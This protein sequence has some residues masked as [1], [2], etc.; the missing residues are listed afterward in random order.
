M[1]DIHFNNSCIC[2]TRRL[3]FHILQGDLF[4]FITCASATSVTYGL[5]S[6][7]S[8]FPGLAQRLLPKSQA[9]VQISSAH[10][11]PKL[12]LCMGNP[13]LG[14]LS[15]VS[16]QLIKSWGCVTYHRSHWG[17]M[18]T[19][20]CNRRMS[21]QSMICVCSRY[22]D[23]YYTSEVID[24]RSWVTLRDKAQSIKGYQEWNVRAK[25]KICINSQM[26]RVFII[27]PGIR[28]MVSTT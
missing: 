26:W 14:T 8:F 7:T 19:S 9:W 20:E 15:F 1:Y 11:Y 3:N 12:I 13:L 27:S 23:H 17:I 5:G 10:T 4:F 18:H 25:F 28:L 2:P 22:I 21:M 16:G 24:P 6:L